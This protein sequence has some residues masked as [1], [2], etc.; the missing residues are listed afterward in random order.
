METTIPAAIPQPPRLC[1]CPRPA[2]TSEAEEGHSWQ[3]PV[4]SSLPLAPPAVD[5]RC[6]S[7]GLP[8][9]F[10]PPGLRSCWPQGRTRIC[11]QGFPWRKTSRSTC[12]FAPPAFSNHALASARIESETHRILPV[13]FDPVRPPVSAIPLP[14]FSRPEPTPEKRGRQKR[15]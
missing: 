6:C 3:R 11:L 2:R 4:L 12:R 15:T 9:P 8:F 14:I 1:I 5:G 13:F 7:Q 10:V